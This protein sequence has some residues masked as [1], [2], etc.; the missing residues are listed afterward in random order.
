MVIVMKK[1]LVSLVLVIFFSIGSKCNILY[2]YDDASGGG[3]ASSYVTT[4][5]TPVSVSWSTLDVLNG[6]KVKLETAQLTYN[7]IS[8]IDRQTELIEDA[9]N[10]SIQQQQDLFYILKNVLKQIQDSIMSVVRNM[11]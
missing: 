10:N 7:E 5:S 6:F 4:S 8:V 2:Y 1:L 11:M 9:I 3:S